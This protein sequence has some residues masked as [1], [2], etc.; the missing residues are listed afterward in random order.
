M[1][2]PGLCPAPTTMAM[3]LFKRTVSSLA[4]P[5]EVWCGSICGRAETVVKKF[6][7]RAC[8]RQTAVPRYINPTQQNE[9]RMTSDAYAAEQKIFCAMRYGLCE[10]SNSA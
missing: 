4:N 10:R 7:L 1:P 5:L 3:R 9:I 6:A 8:E 2:S